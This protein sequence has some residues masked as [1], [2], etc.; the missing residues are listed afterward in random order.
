M[1]LCYFSYVKCVFLSKRPTLLGHKER[2][3]RN[4]TNGKFITI[5]A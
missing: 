2:F 4:T 3:G 5:F 1:F